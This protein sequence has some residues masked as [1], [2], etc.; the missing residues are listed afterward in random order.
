MSFCHHT[1][2]SRTPYPSGSRTAELEN[3]IKDLEQRLFRVNSHTD[4][5]SQGTS[6]SVPS[7][8]TDDLHDEPSA[9]RPRIDPGNESHV[10]VSY[11][12]IM[13]GPLAF[14]DLLIHCRLL[15]RHLSSRL[16][17]SHPDRC[18]GHSTGLKTLRLL[19]K[20]NHALMSSPRESS[21]SIGQATTGQSTLQAVLVLQV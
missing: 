18:S 15:C 17:T 10:M 14:A 19:L 3:K 4:G 6:I 11:S 21:A 16:T 5:Q 1:S 2:T 13:A 7:P 20:R 12:I 9:K 8:N